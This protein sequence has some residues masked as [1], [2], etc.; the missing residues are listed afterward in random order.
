MR[1]P[2]EA[3]PDGAVAAPHHFH[4]AVVAILLVAAIIWDDYPRRE[5]ALVV[6]GLTVAEFGFSLTWPH[7]PVAGA[8]L[9]LYGVFVA[10]LPVSHALVVVGAR[11]LG[12]A[13]PRPYWAL[14]PIWTV[15]VFALLLVAWDD[16]VSHAFG[17]PTPLD[18]IW[19]SHIYPYM[20]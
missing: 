4:W 14:Y 8:V 7:Y 20:A 16:L 19:K 6:A 12:R 18:S 2:H 15:V 10:T 13:W 17:V 1:F 5:P 11:L 3:V 9:S